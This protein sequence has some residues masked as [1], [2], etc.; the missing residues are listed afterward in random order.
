M[1]RTVHFA[2]DTSWGERKDNLGKAVTWQKVIETGISVL[3]GN[4][5]K[6]V[7]KAVT[8]SGP[9][10]PA[11]PGYFQLDKNDGAM[12]REFDMVKDNV[13]VT[14][15]FSEIPLREKFRVREDHGVIKTDGHKEMIKLGESFSKDNAN[16]AE[17]LPV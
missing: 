9:V 6:L 11:E 10:A 17:V 8:T 13:W 16:W 4:S 14:I 5:P 15:P 7:D 2:T 3:E 1:P 12:I